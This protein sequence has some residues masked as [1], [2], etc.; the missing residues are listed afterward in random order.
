MNEALYRSEGKRIYRLVKK[1]I[2][3]DEPVVFSL[4]GVS[5]CGKTYS[6]KIANDL[7]RDDK[8]LSYLFDVAGEPDFRIYEDLS[9]YYP[10]VS[11]TNA[12]KK[13]INAVFCYSYVGAIC[14]STTSNSIGGRLEK[15]IPVMYHKGDIRNYNP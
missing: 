7:L 4:C 12:A 14:M 9:L 13:I 10:V 11:N 5:G 15:Y 2:L 3:N 1:L 6:I 8:D